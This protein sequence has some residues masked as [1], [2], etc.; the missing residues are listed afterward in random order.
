MVWNKRFIQLYS[1]LP[2]DIKIIIMEYNPE[3]R[4]LFKKTFDDIQLNGTFKRLNHLVK[5][6]NTDCESYTDGY[7]EHRQF[8]CFAHLLNALVDDH[9]HL[10]NNL[11]KCRCCKRHQTKRPDSLKCR[12]IYDNPNLG[13]PYSF[14][15]NADEKN[16]NCRCRHS[17]RQLC[18]SY[19]HINF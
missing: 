5:I 15:Y 19:R 17:M 4:R 10:F 3:H 8:Y 1:S 2:V 14:A 18:K 6:Y 9:Q 7:T 12:L 13:T 16:C 11:K